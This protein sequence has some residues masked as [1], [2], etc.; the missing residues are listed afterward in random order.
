MQTRLLGLAGA[1]LLVAYAAFAADD[2]GVAA[3]KGPL[4]L[5][6]GSSAGKPAGDPTL[7]PI[8]A[9]EAP[10]KVSAKGANSFTEAQARRRMQDHGYNVVGNLLQDGNGVWH[11]EVTKGDSKEST[12]VALDYKGDLVEEQPYTNHPTTPLKVAPSA[13]AAQSGS[14]RPAR[15]VDGAP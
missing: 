5:L 13:G 7:R 15:P 10:G 12:M 2:P 1:G 4:N 6:S 3:D 8:E 11:A 9:E 14:T